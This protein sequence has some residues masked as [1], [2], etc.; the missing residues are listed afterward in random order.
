MRYFN[1]NFLRDDRNYVAIHF[2]PQ[3]DRNSA[4]H[5][6]L[7]I[8]IDRKGYHVS[9]WHQRDIA[10]CEK[11]KLKTQYDGIAPFWVESFDDDCLIEGYRHA[12]C[13]NPRLNAREILEKIKSEQ[14]TQRMPP[15]QSIK[16][17]SLDLQ[18]ML[19]AF[20]DY[21]NHDHKWA[22]F[23]GH[24]YHAL[25]AHNCSSIAL[26]LLYQGG[27]E[28]LISGYSD[29]LREWAFLI[30]VSSSFLW[31]ASFVSLCT[32]SL[33]SGL[34]GSAVGGAIDGFQDVQPFLRVCNINKKSNI[35]Y[36]TG[37]IIAAALISAVQSILFK[38]H[39]LLSRFVLP[40]NVLQLVME[41]AKNEASVVNH[42][43]L[44]LT[45]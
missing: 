32:I 34:A 37:M 12:A 38:T 35:A 13:E 25:G 19:A 20:E 11:D 1:N 28:S 4:G 40:G 2:W 16:L 6:S 39:Y 41:A 43:S 33:M 7:T 23:S 9:Y 26:Y 22:F 14:F 30:A 42:V 44:A 29:F 31:V 5:I 24:Q 3:T 8:V 17:Y 18:K 15:S 21:K 10:Q 45:H 36:D 27:M